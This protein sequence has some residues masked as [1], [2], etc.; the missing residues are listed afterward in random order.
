MQ[1]ILNLFSLMEYND[2]QNVSLWQQRY[3]VPQ[4]SPL[5]FLGPKRAYSASTTPINYDGQYRLSGEAE[6]NAVERLRSY[7]KLSDVEINDYLKA[8]ET[9]NP[10]LSVY[11]LHSGY[12][13]DGKIPS[14][15]STRIVHQS[16]DTKLM[17]LDLLKADLIL[18]PV[19]VGDH[20]YLLSI[21]KIKEKN[22]IIIRC[23]DGLNNMGAHVKILKT[24]RKLV[25]LLYG[26]DN[27]FDI[28]MR[29]L[30]NML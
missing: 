5:L 30:I 2:P 24:G 11:A 7:E 21:L 13:H 1:D 26:P 27:G 23:L 15:F 19:C 17:Q 8:I 4:P 14:S 10:S 18:C 12:L 29:S 25:D 28:D 16:N 6:T 20:W 22:Q 3:N 9:R